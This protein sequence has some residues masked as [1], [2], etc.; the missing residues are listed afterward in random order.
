M[1]RRAEPDAQKNKKRKLSHEGSVHEFD[2][3]FL[4]LALKH[5]LEGEIGFEILMLLPKCQSC[6]THVETS[7][8]SGH[9]WDSS[10]PDCFGCKSC[11]TNKSKCRALLNSIQHANIPQMKQLLAWGVNVNGPGIN[12]KSERNFMPDI[13]SSGPISSYPN[14]LLLAVHESSTEVVQI[15]LDAKADPNY[16]WDSVPCILQA[17][18]ELKVKNAETNRNGQN[19]KTSCKEQEQI[20]QLLVKNDADLTSQDTVGNNCVWYLGVQGIQHGFDF[21]LVGHSMRMAHVNGKMMA[22]S[23]G[24]WIASKI[25]QAANYFSSWWPFTNKSDAKESK[26]APKFLFQFLIES[27]IDVNQVNH[28]KQNMLH[29]ILESTNSYEPHHMVSL[30]L[31]LEYDFNPTSQDVD[32]KSSCDLTINIE[33]SFETWM[34]HVD[35]PMR[36]TRGFSPRGLEVD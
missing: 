11:L 14:Y 4:Q 21:D 34:H 8:I 13:P 30:K 7:R 31:L 16:T 3:W 25:S 10:E 27:K 18:E 23:H 20:I 5:G 2:K 6:G 17:C 15:L 24:T 35:Q 22:H 29:S 12:L 28:R 19:C 26:S 36:F 1:K 9:S 32:G 33:T